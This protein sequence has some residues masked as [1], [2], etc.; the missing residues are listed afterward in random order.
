M[1]PAYTRSS[2][3]GTAQILPR[4]SLR[5]TPRNS[6]MIEVPSVGS[7]RNTGHRGNSFGITSNPSSNSRK[8]NFGTSSIN[9]GSRQLIYSSGSAPSSYSKD[10]RPLRDKTYQA[11]IAQKVYNYLL[12]NR[13][14]F[15]MQHPLS[16]KTLKAPTQKDFVA[17]FQ[18]LYNRL[19]PG[20]S[21]TKSIENDVFT[22]LKALSYPYLDS[23]SKSQISAVGGQNWPYYLGMLYW[24][25]EMNMTLEEY[26][27]VAT[28]NVDILDQLFIDY[29]SKA[30]MMYLDGGNDFSNCKNEMIEDFGHFSQ[31]V[32]SDLES[33]E[34]EIKQLEKQLQDLTKKQKVISQLRGRKQAFTSD[35]GKFKE[36]IN[37]MEKRKLKWSQLLLRAKE[38]LVKVSGDLKKIQDEKNELQARISLQRI[39]PTEID[40]MNS[41]K[42]K[43]VDLSGKMNLRLSDT[44]VICDKNEMKA[45]QNLDVLEKSIQ[46]YHSSLDHIR[47]KYLP[48]A[49]GIDFLIQIDNPLSDENLG[50]YSKDIISTVDLHKVNKALIDLRNDIFVELRSKREE[51][52]E[53]KLQIENL[54]DHVKEKDEE[55][56]EIMQQLEELNKQQIEISNSAYDSIADLTREA[57]LL[58][59]QI[60]KLRT[61]YS[62]N[63]QILQEKLH[64]L[65]ITEQQLDSNIHSRLLKARTDVGNMIDHVAN[66]KIFTRMSLEGFE[67]DVENI[68]NDLKK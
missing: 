18:W 36:Y 62:Q 48:H 19:D 6:N 25:V 3:F 65:Q 15:E 13:F 12:A 10:P 43:L 5:V 53:K 56:T 49:K 7:N 63:D 32:R 39:G 64:T 24:L 11:T 14:E 47:F 23:M 44:R 46:Q 27:S 21:F 68:K 50:R 33:L 34:E 35:I 40:E 29:I 67:D 58:E 4:Q 1:A 52:S 31:K 60:E 17:I 2:E 51:L 16:Q 38:E 57:E 20:Y 22:L 28:Q 26:D 54:M 37:T 55:E 61:S 45:Q 41:R 66:F 8:S 9:T 59:N 30:Y 42:E